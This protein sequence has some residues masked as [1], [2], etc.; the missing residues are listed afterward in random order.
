MS[1]MQGFEVFF[2][3]AQVVRES[4]EAIY[5]L[6]GKPENHQYKYI[7]GFTSIIVAF[8]FLVAIFERVNPKIHPVKLV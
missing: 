8:W 1:P 7:I 4:T 3:F 5:T 6:G 2:L